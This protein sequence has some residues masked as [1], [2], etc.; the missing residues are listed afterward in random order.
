LNDPIVNVRPS[1]PAASRQ[2]AITV[3]IVSHG[4]ADLLGPLLAQLCQAERGAVGRVV[5]THNLPARPLT[6]PTGGW[7]FRFTEIFN[8]SPKGF[9]ANHN[10][11]FEQADTPLFCVLN[12]DV[13]LSDGGI[14]AQMA[15]RA[16]EA[17]AGC[18]FPTLLNEDGSRQDNVREVVT[19]WA[20]FRRR[21]LRRPQRGMDWASAAF[22]VVP[23][24]VYR[25]LGGFDERFF[26]YCEDV[27]FCLRLQLQGY[28]LIPVP[29]RAQHL[30]HRGSHRHWRHLA[31]HVR[32]LIRLWT[33]APLRE[34]LQ[35]KT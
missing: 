9:G 17:D 19:P 33:G 28:R 15:A 18:V 1:S 4:H 2:P 7:P 22:W 26:M 5:V 31:W 34:Y 13:S 29:A 11:A 21:V 35:R 12:P 27:D 23:S 24:A 3:S 6:P 25:Q 8:A 16:C 14:W 10:R 20:L 32:S 30:A